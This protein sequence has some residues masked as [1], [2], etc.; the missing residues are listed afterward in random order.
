MKD[1]DMEFF[2]AAIARNVKYMSERRE[3]GLLRD[4]VGSLLTELQLKKEE[5]GKLKEE[6]RSLKKLLQVESTD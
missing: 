3:K 2:G 1:D 4:Y 6:V 5:C